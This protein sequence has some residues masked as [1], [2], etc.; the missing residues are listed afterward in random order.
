ML[1]RS[2][3]VNAVCPGW[4]R[5]PMAEGRML[6]LGMD[7]SSLQKSV[8]LGRFMEPEEVAE[9]VFYLAGEGAGGITG[10]ALVVDGGAIG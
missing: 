2:I 8:P 10:Q 7:E 6:E 9:L 4:T 3:T 5:T 1:F